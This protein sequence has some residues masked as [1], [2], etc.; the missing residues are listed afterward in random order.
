[1]PPPAADPSEAR[2]Q[3]RAL[4][5]FFA[6]NVL[7][8]A[9]QWAHGFLYNF[10]L[11][12]LSAG[13]AMM[14]AA[15]AALTAGGL[16]GLVPAGAMIDRVGARAAFAAAAG[17]SAAGLAAGAFVET[18]FGLYTTSF[19]AGIGVAAWRVC[20]GPLVMGL[21][22]G[23][24]RPRAF[25][26]N[27]SLLLVSGALWTL[28]AGYVPGWMGGGLV[29]VRRALLLSALLTLLSAPVILR[30]RLN[31]ALAAPP[32]RPTDS[33]DED[34][35]GSVIDALRRF[36]RAVAIPPPLLGIIAIV[37]VWMTATGLVIPFFNVFFNREHALPMPRVGELMAAA[38]LVTAAAVL[39]SGEI[40]A[41]MGPRWALALWLLVFPP[42]LFGLAVTQSLTVAAA[43]F[44]LQNFAAPATFPLID[45]LLLER[46]PAGRQGVVASWRGVA[47]EG[48]GLVG[49]S[50]G[51]VLLERASF[52]GLFA[53]SGGLGLA[54]ALGLL[55]VFRPFRRRGAPIPA[56]A[57]D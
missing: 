4:A 39:G 9:G 49:A 16:A 28:G 23:E 27:V 29:G 26:W 31:P 43:L 22:E 48:S 3:R 2:R 19:V 38:Q 24:T 7:F 50:W 53:L 33:T 45:Q 32:S 5:L 51:G 52:S 57:G 54:A 8:G 20:M 37:V 15:A 42:A 12:E 25:S 11:G 46:A 55:A 47:T 17:V 21:A 35:G 40:A 18:P 56:V 34:S 36:F 10:Y 6:A 14:G 30:V 44:L 41:R 13:T 1:M